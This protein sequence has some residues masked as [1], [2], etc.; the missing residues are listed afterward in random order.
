MKATA[1]VAVTLI[2]ACGGNSGTEPTVTPGSV[3]AGTSAGATASTNPPPAGCADV[4]SVEIRGGGPYTFAVTV[5]S[6]DEGWDKYADEWK[7]VAE[8][9][10]IVGVR[11]LTHPHVEEQPFTRSLSGVAVD[12]GSVV[13]VSAR[14]SI[15]GYCGESISVTVAG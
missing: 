8:D 13:E 10:S 12:P 6:P 14:D 15:E 3:D 7:I 11:E 1:L 5:A 9:G 2:I 4:V